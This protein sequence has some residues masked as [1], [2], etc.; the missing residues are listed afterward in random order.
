M[1]IGK[2]SPAIIDLPVFG[3]FD[4]VIKYMDYAATGMGGA[5]AITDTLNYCPGT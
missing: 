5:E 1:V 2:V 3:E 4:T